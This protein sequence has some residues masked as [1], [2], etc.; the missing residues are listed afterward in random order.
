MSNTKPVNR[1]SRYTRKEAAQ[2]LGVTEGTLS[3]WATTGRYNLPYFKAGRLVYYF[4][5]DLN[6]FIERRMCGTT[7]Q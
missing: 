4:E 5:A 7:G 2:F 6:A 1:G 3:V